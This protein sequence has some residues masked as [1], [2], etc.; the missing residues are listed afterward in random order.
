MFGPGGVGKTEL[1]S[2]IQQL[3]IKPLFLDVEDGSKF[4]DVPRV[5]PKPET[6]DEL[7]QVLQTTEIW[8]GYNAVVI[9]SL[10]KCEQLAIQWTLQNVKTEKGGFVSSVEGYGFGKGYT[11]VYETFLQ[12]LGDLDAHVRQGRHV[13]CVAHECAATVPNPTGEDYLQFQPRLQCP[14]GG[15]ASIRHQVKEWA[16]HLLFIGFDI[17][18]N[19]DGK[20]T[21][22]GTRTIYPTELPTWW[23]KSRLLADPIPYEKHDAEVWRQMLN[24]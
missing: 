9:D 21:G 6:W 19:E 12:L 22:A 10:T 11:H 20:G 4:L 14:N 5:D 16:D 17:A 15:K 13:I 24:I 2:N 23:A 1:C 3:G 8:E 7:R 18:V